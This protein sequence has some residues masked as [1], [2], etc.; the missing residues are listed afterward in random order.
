MEKSC[1][2][3]FRRQNCPNGYFDD[4]AALQ[5]T[6]LLVTEFGEQWGG[7]D[8]LKFA[9]VHNE[10]VAQICNLLYRILFCWWW[11]HTAAFRIFSVCRLEICATADWKSAL[12]CWMRSSIARAVPDTDE[13]I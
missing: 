7:M 9:G 5:T 12:R 10:G 1:P 13:P 2:L 3:A 8:F 6:Q 11:V 4:C